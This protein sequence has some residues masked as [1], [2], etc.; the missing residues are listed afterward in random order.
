VAL[1]TVFSTFAA[2]GALYLAWQTVRETRAMR[3]EDSREKRRAQLNR[4]ELRARFRPWR[5]YWGDGL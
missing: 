2:L 4:I 5:V 1:F 3:G